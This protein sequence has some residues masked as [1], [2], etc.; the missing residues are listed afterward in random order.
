MNARAAGVLPLALALGCGIAYAQPIP[1]Q[2]VTVPFESTALFSLATGDV[3]GYAFVILEMPSNGI[4]LGIPPHLI[5][6]PRPGFSGTDWITFAATSPQGLLELGTVKIL[7]LRPE[8][9]MSMPALLAE[10]E[11]VF[12][13]PAFA[14]D[15]HRFVFGLQQRFRYFE[16]SLRGTW[17]DAV[18]TSFV[19]TTRVELEGTVPSP[20]RLPITSTL[21][22]DPTIPGLS[23]WTVDART[24]VLGATW[25]YTF[26]YSGT[27]PQTRSYAT[28]QVQGKI[29][30]FTFDSLT[31]FVSLT[32]TF[33]EQRLLLRGPWICEGCPTAWEL[34]FL[35]TKA[36]FR[37]LSFLIRDVE[38]PCPA[39]AG[40]Q[41]LFDTRATFTV[42]EKKIEPA[43]R[44]KSSFV[45]CVRPLVSL[46]TPVTGVGLEGIELYGMEIRCDVVGGYTLRL[47]TSFDPRRDSTVT[48]DPRFF[49][50]WQLEGPVVPC[51]GHPGRFQISAYFKR[52]SENL[53]GLGMWNVII[54]FPLSREFLVNIGLKLGEVDTGKTWILT[55]GWRGLW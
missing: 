48:G 32:P 39:C 18:F 9:Q 33:G 1:V 27:D 16:Q 24:T 46:V 4:L 36:G 42:D 43:L 25:V 51:C 54:Y 6:I 12:S 44:I 5:Y 34:E 23:S 47:V 21:N 22:F 29:G 11:F 14:I 19:A 17:T 49:E 13:G 55:V 26:F 10:G 8:E 30:A 37:Y 31:K 3:T 52:G 35:H 50:L 53:F 2:V 41:V 40:M 38:I 28:L 15:R 7:V 20:W 45:A